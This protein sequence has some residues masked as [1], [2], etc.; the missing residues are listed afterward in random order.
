MDGKCS[1][2]T[3]S[4]VQESHQICLKLRREKWILYVAIQWQSWTT[5]RRSSWIPMLMLINM[6]LWVND[7]GVIGALYYSGRDIHAADHHFEETS[8]NEDAAEE[9]ESADQFE[10]S[11]VVLH[12]AEI[13]K[14]RYNNKMDLLHAFLLHAALCIS[15]TC[16]INIVLIRF[17]RFVTAMLVNLISV[18]IILAFANN[19]LGK[20]RSMVE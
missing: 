13:S 4:S 10:C 14:R 8:D 12:S 9:S 18:V 5:E 6:E 3:S 11:G 20:L 15:I 7:E 16:H 17:K 1:R 2:K 19:T